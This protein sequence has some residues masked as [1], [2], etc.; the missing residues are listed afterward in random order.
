M[1]LKNIEIES[2]RGI[3]N[4]I[5]VNF[6]KNDKP[7]STI[8]FG[9][10]GTGKSSIID[11]IEYN[12]QGKLERSDSLN[13]EFRPS[14]RNLYT[15]N[16]RCFTKI[17]FE[18]NSSFERLIE[19]HYDDEKEQLQYIRSS[20]QLNN[21]FKIAPIALRR[22]DI[23]NYSLTSSKQ[24]QILFWSFIYNIQNKVPKEVDISDKNFINEL[25]DERLNLKT[26]RKEIV[27]LLSNELKI[28]IQEIP[29]IGIA[30]LF[31]IL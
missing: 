23:I 30:L 10:N 22:N 12:L 19:I 4:S 21:Y 9:D 18:D 16:K 17:I 29:L 31:S 8:I 1:K 5:C 2:F 25:N 24:K 11:A 20:N 6:S 14:V 13:N 15:N 26:L 27:E 7:I 3:S 28:P